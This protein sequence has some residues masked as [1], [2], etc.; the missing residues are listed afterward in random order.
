MG[1]GKILITDRSGNSSE[2][3]LRFATTVDDVLKAINLNKN[4]KV[5]A[6]VSGDRIVLK[7]LTGQ[8]TSN[9]K[10]S[11]VDVVGKRRWPRS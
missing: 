9:L 5:S 7:D 4:I 8:T 1:K 10:V 11:E 6:S 3:D 2:I